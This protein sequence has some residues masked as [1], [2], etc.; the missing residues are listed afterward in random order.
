M[1]SA[2]DDAVPTWRRRLPAATAV[3]L[4][5]IAV[6]PLAGCA[7]NRPLAS[8]VNPAAAHAARAPAVRTG[9][10]LVY[11]ATYAPT[12]EQS[13]YPVH[14]DYTIA[15]TQDQVIEHVAN[16]S[17]PFNAYPATVTLPS[18]EYHVRA[19]YDRGGFIVFTVEVKPGKTTM[20]NLN[21]EPL[22]SAAD[23]TRQPI[24]LPDGRTVGW[25]ATGG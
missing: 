21:N 9:K 23:P 22:S 7:T 19:Q 24:R 5:L 15:T 16:A 10:L 1:R 6:M 14:T 3:K 12:G 11:S 20:V 18:G 4:A 25:R 8:S 2:P 17:G 13:E